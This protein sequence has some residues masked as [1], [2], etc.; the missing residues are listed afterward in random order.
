MSGEHV[1]EHAPCT[2]SYTRSRTSAPTSAWWALAATARTLD[3]S[4]VES[5][6]QTF[7]SEPSVVG[8]ERVDHVKLYLPARTALVLSDR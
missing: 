1:V 5:H 2:A 6:D 7:F 4:Y 3:V 8:D